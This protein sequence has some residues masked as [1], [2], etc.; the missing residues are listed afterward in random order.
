VKGA[1]TRFMARQ[2]SPAHRGAGRCVE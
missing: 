2:E 1:E